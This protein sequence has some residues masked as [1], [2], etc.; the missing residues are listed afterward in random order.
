MKTC[1]VLQYQ[2]KQIVHFDTVMFI[3]NFALTISWQKLDLQHTVLQLELPLHLQ[4]YFLHFVE[5]DTPNHSNK[6]G[7]GIMNVP[8][9]L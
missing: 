2:I 8:M 1:Q 6:K 7:N 5:K 3:V 4:Q 9:C